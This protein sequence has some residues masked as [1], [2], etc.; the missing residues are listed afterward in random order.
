MPNKGA[1]RD[2]SE[3]TKW[4][5]TE[6]DRERPDGG[7]APDNSEISRRGKTEP[8]TERADGPAKNSGGL[9]GARGHPT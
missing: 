8:D 5:E 3:K 7:A 2:K 1:I 4:E 9:G 6:P